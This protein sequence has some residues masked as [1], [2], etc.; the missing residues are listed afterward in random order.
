MNN[1]EPV[2]KRDHLEPRAKIGDVVIVKLKDKEYSD[3]DYMQVTITEAKC[4]KHIDILS[5]Q[6]IGGYPSIWIFSAQSPGIWKKYKNHV[7][8][9]KD[10]LKNLTTNKSYA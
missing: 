5:I 10:I 8:I 7:F 3:Y 2:T 1:L 4:H 9:N 6:P